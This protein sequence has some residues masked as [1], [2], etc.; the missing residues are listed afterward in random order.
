[1]QYEFLT[2]VH[3]DAPDGRRVEIERGRIIGPDDILPGCL[4]SCLAVGWCRKR[5]APRKG[6]EP[7]QPARPQPARK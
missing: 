7:L 4:A 1:M 2:D 5:E 6:D 3:V